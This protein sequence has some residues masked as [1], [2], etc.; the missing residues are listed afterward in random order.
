MKICRLQDRCKCA[1]RD[2]GFHFSVEGTLKVAMEG[3][4][5]GVDGA[6]VVGVD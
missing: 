4:F 5:E 3:H 1:F 2:E 6:E